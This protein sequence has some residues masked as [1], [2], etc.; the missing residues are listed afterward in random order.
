ME[1]GFLQRKRAARSWA[2]R[3]TTSH[4]VEVGRGPK[5]EVDV[6]LRGKGRTPPT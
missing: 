1:Q 6:N 5:D 2:Q 3:L 4:L